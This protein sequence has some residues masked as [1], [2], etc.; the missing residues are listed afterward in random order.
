MSEKRRDHKGRLLKTGESQRKDLTYQYRFT[1]IDGVRRTVY[2][3]TLSE[4][5]EKEKDIQKRLEDDVSFAKG[6]ITVYTLFEDYINSK[7]NI[8]DSTRYTYNSVLRQIKDDPFCQLSISDVNVLAAKRWFIKL[9]EN[10]YSFS[11]IK[12]YRSIARDSFQSAYECDYISKNPFS[13]SLGFLKND[14]VKRTA[15][16]PDQQAEYLRFIES[17]PYS[18][19]YCNIYVLLLETGLRISEFCGLT[20]TDIDMENRVITIDHQLC[21]ANGKH[22]KIS[23]PKSNAGIRKIPITQT[24]Y[25]AIC[26]IIQARPHTDN[27]IMVDGRTGFLYITKNGRPSLAQ[28]VSLVFSKIYERYCKSSYAPT[29]PKVTPHI[30]RHTFCTNMMNAGMNP[31][32]VQ[33]LM[34]HSNVSI[35]FNTYTHCDFDSVVCSMKELS[36]L[37]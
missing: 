11:T 20:L 17:D 5:R 10:G 34:G 35:T 13:F 1:D 36:L 8:K 15:L 4:L 22:L 33:Y 29:V 18:E 9:A 37:R 24:A 12:I 16:T 21:K 31:K 3:P 28:N 19:Q 32:H 2:S 26:G 23:S 14:G 27:E 30:L 25:D 7:R 6:N